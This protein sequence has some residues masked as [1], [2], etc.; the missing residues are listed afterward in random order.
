MPLLLIAIFSIVSIASLFFLFQRY[1][2]ASPSQKP[3]IIWA[4]F[5]AF[6]VAAGLFF[7]FASR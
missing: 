1:Q 6:T 7:L 5:A 4:S 2:G 3:Q